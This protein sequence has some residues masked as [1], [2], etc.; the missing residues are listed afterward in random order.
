M[1]GVKFKGDYI[2]NRVC[3]PYGNHKSALRTDAEYRNCVE[4]FHIS[5]T[6]SILTK[7]PNINITNSFVLDYMY[8]I[9][10]GVMRK[11]IS[12][13]IIKRLANVCLSGRKINEITSLLLQ[14]KPYKTSDFPR[15]PQ[16]VQ[17]I[18]RWK[19]TELRLFLI[20]LG[21]FV[22][23]NITLTECFD[24]FM[25]LNVAMIV[26]LSSDKGHYSEYTQQLLDYFVMT[27]DEIYGSFNI[28]QNIHGLIDITSD[29]NRYGP[30]DQYSCFL[31][32][33]H[34][35]EIKKCL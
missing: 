23:K 2:N 19:A 33:N 10:L 28:S 17:D 7:I 30:L 24:N 13:W 6:P 34:M 20:Y 1:H 3:F 35:K 12:F 15:K 16:E 31:F 9:N 26:L 8:L 25:A 11:L 18:S 4:D 21:P 22:L 29:F 32:E 5:N 27:F 14:T